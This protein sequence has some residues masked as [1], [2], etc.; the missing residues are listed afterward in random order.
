MKNHFLNF[1]LLLDKILNFGIESI[2]NR[3]YQ[4]TRKYFNNMKNRKENS[5]MKEYLLEQFLNDPQADVGTGL[6]ASRDFGFCFVLKQPHRWSKNKE[7]VPILP[8]GGIG[9]K[10]EK[11]ELPSQSLHRESLE[12]VGSD[13]EITEPNRGTILID[14]ESIRKISLSTDLKS[15]PLPLIIFQSPRAEAGRKPITNVLI[16]VGRFASNEIRPLDDPALIELSGKLLI[17]IADKPMAVEEFQRAGGKITSRIELP[18]NGIL[19]PIGTAIAA[20]QCIK[21]GFITDEILLER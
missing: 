2:S 6:L 13:V 8:F 15:E 17:R 5:E 20:A 7:G 21:V 11:N 18:E 16:Y 3:K 12:E 9:G 4:N 1:R 19:Q 14:T 10:L